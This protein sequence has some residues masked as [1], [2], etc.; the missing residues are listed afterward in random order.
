MAARMPA[1]MSESGAPH[2][3]GGPSG[4]LAGEAHDAAH[5]LGDEVEA[6]PVLVG[7]GAAEAG[8]RAV[9]QAGIVLAQ[10]LVAEAEALHRAR[11]EILDQHVGDGDQPAQHLRR[12]PAS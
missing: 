7:P 2:F 11:R 8:Q 6:A 3:T 5:R 10:I 1:V 12:R 4:P 9:D